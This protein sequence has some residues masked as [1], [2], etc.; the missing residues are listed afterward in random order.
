MFP[1]ISDIKKIR[2]KVEITQKELAKRTGLSQSYIARLENGDLNPSYENLK[3][4]FS[5]LEYEL[6]KR[7]EREI[8]VKDVMTRD[9]IFVDYNESVDTAMRI[10]LKYGFSQLPVMKNGQVV[11]SITESVI[12]SKISNGKSPS[13]LK[14]LKV[15]EIMEEPFPIVGESTPIKI[16]AFLLKFYPAI[17]VTNGEKITGIVTKADL[18]KTI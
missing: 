11:G 4:I 12:S 17:I 5:V 10:F 3:K 9:V 13:E 18:L 14:R 1:D 8:R 6:E 2:K 7:E 15:Y 16:A